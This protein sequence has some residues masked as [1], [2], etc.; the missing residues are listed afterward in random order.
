MRLSNTSLRNDRRSLHVMAGLVPAIRVKHCASWYK[1]LRLDVS[2]SDHLA[3][4]FGLVG[5]EFAKGG[6]RAGKCRGAQVSEA[7]LHLVIGKA[8]IYQVI[9]LPDDFDRRVLWGAY[10]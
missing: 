5:D 4:L 2:C 10:A 6:G 3:P 1:S 9:E 7:R 8:C